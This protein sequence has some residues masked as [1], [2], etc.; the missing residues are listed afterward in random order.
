M[1]GYL[2]GASRALRQAVMAYLKQ[3]TMGDFNSFLMLFF[4]NLALTASSA[5]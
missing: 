3:V 5:V 4:D 1:A 2:R